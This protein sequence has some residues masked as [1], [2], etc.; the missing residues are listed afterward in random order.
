MNSSMNSLD[1]KLTQKIQEIMD[2]IDSVSSMIDYDN[3]NVNKD[4]TNIDEKLAELNITQ[5]KLKD[6]MNSSIYSLDLKLTQK[7]QEIIDEIDSVSSNI[8]NVD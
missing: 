1:L 5:Y 8:T 6:N 3:L 7:M 4:L 2:K